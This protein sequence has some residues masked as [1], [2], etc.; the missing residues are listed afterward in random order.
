MNTQKKVRLYKDN[1]TT[2]LNEDGTVKTF[3]QK[4]EQLNRFVYDA[5]KR[6]TDTHNENK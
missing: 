2:T 5:L 1:P 4:V 3:Q 6:M